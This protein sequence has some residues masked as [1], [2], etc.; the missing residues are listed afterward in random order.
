MNFENPVHLVAATAKIRAEYLKVARTV[1]ISVQQATINR[2]DPV[3]GPVWVS[4]Y[5]VPKPTNDTSRDMLVSS[6][7]ETNEK[8]VP[9]HRPDS[10]ALSFEWTGF[11]SNVN[12]H[13]P[14]PPLREEEKFKLIHL[15]WQFYVKYLVQ[16]PKDSTD[17]ASA[18]GP[19]E[20]IPGCFA[21]CVPVLSRSSDTAPPGI[22]T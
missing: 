5:T 12:N 4:K 11:R 10:T 22:P 1:S 16:L 18:S 17:G 21:G 13:T 15:R 7:D 2:N 6:I 14:E 19:A 8:N 9:Y 3:K 20:C